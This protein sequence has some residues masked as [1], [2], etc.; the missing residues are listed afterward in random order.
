[1]KPIVILRFSHTEGPGFLEHYLNARRLPWKLV[2]LDQGEPVPSSIVEISG[3]ALMGGPMSVNDELPW[4]T[5]T[6]KLINDAVDA[7][8]P[9]IG[10]CLGGQ[11]LAKALGAGVKDNSCIEMGWGSVEVADQ[12]VAGKWFGGATRFDVFHW[13]YQTFD[14]PQG[15]IRVMQSAWCEN[16]AFIYNHRHIGFQC[17]IEMTAGMVRDWCKDGADQLL[18]AKLTPSV[19]PVETILQELPARVSSLNGLASNVYARWI[20]NIENDGS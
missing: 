15:A 4:I 17:H 11:L 16:Q 2:C 13:H 7:K 20:S 8:V 1:M 10:H 9:V 18:A 6:L 19:Q 3:L 14:I 12:A 5:P